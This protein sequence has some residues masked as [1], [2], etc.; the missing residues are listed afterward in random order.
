MK[1]KLNYIPGSMSFAAG[2][3]G[4]LGDVGYTMVYDHNKAVEII[5]TLDMNHIDLVTAGLDGDWIENSDVIFKGKTFIEAGDMWDDDKFW[6][7]DNSIW[8]TPIMIVD[9]DD[10]PS[11][12]YEVWRKENIKE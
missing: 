7:H 3:L 10:R 6:F 12:T 11:E 9:Y 8:A 1:K 2:F 4:P 5:K